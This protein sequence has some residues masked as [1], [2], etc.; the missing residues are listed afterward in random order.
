VPRASLSRALI[1]ALAAAAVAGAA[2]GDGPPA[3]PAPATADAGTPAAVPVACTAGAPPLDA[4]L[5][6]A[7]PERR[8]GRTRI[9]G[10][11]VVVDA[12][13]AVGR[14]FRLD[15][16]TLH[17]AYQVESFR[18]RFLPP[19]ASGPVRLDFVRLLPAGHYLLHL[20]LVEEPG[21]RCWRGDQTVDV[22][23][24]GAPE[25]GGG[26]LD[27]LA[28][29]P[30]VRLLYP[31][32]QLLTG[33]VRFDADVSDAGVARLAFELD[34]RRVLTRS[35]PPWSVELDLGNAPR[36]HRLA[37]IAEDA[38]GVELARD[39]VLLNAGPQRFAVRLTLSPPADGRVLARAEVDVPDEDRL[40]RLELRVDGALV[41]VL[42][43]PPFEQELELPA[44]S[45]WVRA[46][47]WL[48]DGGAAEAVRMVGGATPGESLDVD[49]VEL[50]ATVLDRGGHPVD[51]LRPEEV[52]LSE[53]GRPQRLR[54]FE[55]VGDVPIHAAVLLDTSGS[56]AEELG[57]AEAAALRFFQ[58]VL[59]P[60][61]RAAV[62]TF[63]DAPHL[64]V[65]FTGRLDRL[66]GG[67]ADLR[68]AGE[69]TLYDSLAF[70]LHYFNGL[71]GKRAIVLLSDG[72]DSR[73]R[74]TFEE[75][76]DFA[77]RSGV[78]IYTIGLAIPSNPPEPGVVLDRLARETGGR[79]FRIDHAVQLG[80]IYER[81]ERELRA[82]WL[83]AYQSDA[84][85][86]TAFRHVQVRILRPG[87][88]ARTAEGY[89][90]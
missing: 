46:V 9:E 11:L 89:Y 54:R 20:A 13:P 19:S 64:A 8:A 7:F 23:A 3:G 88:T 61:D 28:A 42:Y 82:Q 41:A 85:G 40:D 25:P 26:G 77:R 53:D 71:S 31:A 60:K 17:G 69:T 51:D 44:G 59:T 10:R 80:P 5:E 81:I 45:V 76:L 87:C 90:P 83:L 43:Q 4:R 12:A 86:G 33:K 30:S 67:V 48:A 84:A 36:L 70:A 22:P 52:E 24:L 16:E 39:E 38:G 50:Y 56:M 68:A 32:D 75:V 55:R 78:A 65:R 63:A 15:G 34:G 66:A 18:F 57:D 49:F 29:A 27:A 62:I 35:R 2:R 74:T 37:A 79:S 73:S 72:A 21:G 47:A 6:L 58:Q 1:L 14:A